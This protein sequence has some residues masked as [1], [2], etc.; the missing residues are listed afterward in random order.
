M[1]TASKKLSS[2]FKDYAAYHKTSGN[3]VTHYFG[4]PMIVIS[5]LGLLSHLVIVPTL[6]GSAYFQLDGGVI[7]W[8]GAVLW[9]LYLDWK[10]AI[11]F[12]VFNL[13][14]YFLGRALPVPICWTLFV[15]GWIFQLVGHSVYEKKSPAFLTNVTHLLVG[16]IWIFARLIGYK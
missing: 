6:G 11:P 5:L 9:Y 14:L 2:Y 4:I 7:L 13:G 10:L 12:A 1:P 8:A 16:P 3:K 15:G